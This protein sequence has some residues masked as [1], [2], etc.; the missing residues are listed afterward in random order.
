MLKRTYPSPKTEE[1]ELDRFP[2]FSPR[3][4]M[5]NFLHLYRQGHSILLE[6]LFGNSDNTLVICETPVYPYISRSRD[7]RIPDLMIAFGVDVQRIIDEVATP[8]ITMESHRSSSWRWHLPAIRGTT[9]CASTRTTRPSAFPSTGAST[10]PGGGVTRWGW[11]GDRLVDGSYQP[12]PIQ[13][14]PEGD[15]YWGRSQVLGVDICWQA[16]ELLW[17]DPA[18]QVFLTTVEEQLDALIA[19]NE[20]GPK[21]NGNHVWRR[22]LGPEKNVSLVWRQKPASGN[23]KRVAAARRRVTNKTPSICPEHLPRRGRPRKVKGEGICPPLRSP[24]CQSR[25]SMF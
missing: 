6:R 11:P 9:W 16:G 8:S 23:W 24:S 10:L 5:Q 21:K 19:A 25:P 7:V 13:H 18:A 2:D 14:N 20:L 1:D 12:I 15:L 4:D 3:S 17:W 22:R